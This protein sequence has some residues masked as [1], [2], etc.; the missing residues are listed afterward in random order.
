MSH[1]LNWTE[2]QREEYEERAAILEDDAGM[3][4]AE[5]EAMAVKLVEAKE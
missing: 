5:A 4:R 2:A 1:S 3:I